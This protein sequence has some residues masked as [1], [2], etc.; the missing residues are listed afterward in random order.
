M[1]TSSQYITE[2]RRNL[3]RELRHQRVVPTSS[4]DSVFPP[5]FLKILLSR[6]SYLV[7]TEAFDYLAHLLFLKLI[8][9]IETAHNHVNKEDSA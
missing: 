2:I 9:S 7:A 6:G 8:A 3:G 1:V 4:K 5:F